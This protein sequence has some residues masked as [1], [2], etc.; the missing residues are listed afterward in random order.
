MKV[1]RDGLGYR[2]AIVEEGVSLSLDR[3]TETRGD[4][5][6][7]LTVSRAPEGHVMRSR[8][9]ISSSHARQSAASYLARRA[10]GLD[11]LGALEGF[12]VEVLR[13]ER[14]GSPPVAIGRRPPRPAV[15]LVLDPLLPIGK[16]TILFGEEG[17]GKSTLAAA[18]AVAVASGHPTFSR[19][20]VPA[21]RGVLILDWE[22]D[23]AD[24]NDVVAACSAGIG[25]E[26]PDNIWHSA[27]ARS[28]TDDVNRIARL[29]QE[30][31][32]GLLIVDSVGLASPSTRDG[33]DASE[34]AL[35]LFGALRVLGTTSLLIDHVN[36]SAES[37]RNSRPYGSVYKPALARATYEL[38]AGEEPDGDGARHLALFHRKGNTT[39][40]QPPVGIKVY[41]TDEEVLLTWEP[42]ELGD[43]SIAKGATLVDRLRDALRSGSRTVTELSD[44]T[45][46]SEA[47]IRKVLSRHDELFVAVTKPGEKAKSWGLVASVTVSRDSVAHGKRDSDSPPK[48][49]RGHGVS[50]LPGPHQ[51]RAFGGLA[52]ANEDRVG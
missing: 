44:L 19:W 45:E 27:C 5:Y 14:A 49:E 15:E 24:W 8:L 43:A 11:W 12:C 17:T 21:P 36:K 34:G 48:G 41:R 7:E 4:T 22:A 13:Q 18:I 16:P 23:E 40:I 9:A 51:Q 33:A 30:H 28:L 32:V 52:E 46:S 10:R 26:P 1:E 2:A 47:V 35:R 29:V 38:R 31:D 3:I 50:H 20:R 39:R 37:G 42:V 6:G 25:I